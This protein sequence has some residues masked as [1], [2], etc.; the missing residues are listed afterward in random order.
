[1]YLG[2]PMQPELHRIHI[3]QSEFMHSFLSYIHFQA[4]DLEL[5]VFVYVCFVV[6]IY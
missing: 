5:F 3:L 2:F 6:A 4:T 1:M